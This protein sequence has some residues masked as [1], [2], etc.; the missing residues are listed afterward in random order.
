MQQGF[1]YQHVLSVL[2]AVVNYSGSSGV[3][4]RTFHS[5]LQDADA[6]YVNSVCHTE[7]P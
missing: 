3:K 2:S 1:K 6:E 4:N 7:V 5:I